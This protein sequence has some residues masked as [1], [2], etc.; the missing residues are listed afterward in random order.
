MKDHSIFL[1]NS[2]YSILKLLKHNM[3]KNPASNK[4]VHP[5][6]K[7]TL[8]ESIKMKKIF[9]KL[10]NKNDEKISSNF[11]T[12]YTGKVFV[13][14]KHNVVVEEVLAEGEI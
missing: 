2:G 10:E 1:L 13:I 3:W 7:E 5:F 9:S 4:F 12:N 11:V 8:N 14:N 6:S